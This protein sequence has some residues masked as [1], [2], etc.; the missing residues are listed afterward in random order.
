LLVWGA[1][2]EPDG[3]GPFGESPATRGRL[4]RLRG[5]DVL[6]L[7]FRLARAT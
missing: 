5:V 3:A 7:L 1:G 4:G 6:P 2:V